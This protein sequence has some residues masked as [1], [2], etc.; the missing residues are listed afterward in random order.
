MEM[1]ADNIKKAVAPSESFYERT[2]LMLG[3]EAVEK[4]RGASVIVFGLGGVGGFVVE[5]LARGGVGT[6]GLVDMDTV[7]YS[8]LNRQI[9]ATQS[10]LGM[11]KTEAARER[12][13]SINPST[14]V[15]T[16]PVFYRNGE[17]GMPPLGEY[18][19]AVD[20]IDTVTSKL[21]LIEAAKSQG[22]PLISCMGTGNKLDPTR[23]RISDISKTREDPLARAVRLGMKKR[24]L[25]GLEVLWSDEPP[26]H[27]G[28]RTPGSVSFVPSAAGL[29][30]GGE[31]IKRIVGYKR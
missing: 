11:L 20:A 13:L 3:E 27:T 9:I 12:V 4:L 23:F 29:I 2:S 7:A 22:V 8:N 10:T 26:V 28:T 25:S 18:S 16:Y 1:T 21:D 17:E 6:L 31:V 19:F 15:H 14:R 24:G 5:A 30:I